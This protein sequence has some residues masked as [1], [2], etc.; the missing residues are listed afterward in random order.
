MTQLPILAE[1]EDLKRF[2]VIDPETGA[3]TM[4]EL[5]G[6]VTEKG[7]ALVMGLE[8]IEDENT[9]AQI[10]RANRAVASSKVAIDNAGK[11]IKD[12]WQKKVTFIDGER[13]RMRLA[14]EELQEQI[15]APVTEWERKEE[16]RKQR[17]TEALTDLAH[18]PHL[19]GKNSTELGEMQD[20]KE[21]QHHDFDWM[22]FADQAAEVRQK[23]LSH[24]ITART[25][26]LERE[27]EAKRQEEERKRLEEEAAEAQ[28]KAA[29]E[30]EKRRA[31]EEELAALRREKEQ[32]EAEERAK[33]EAPAPTFESKRSEPEPEVAPAVGVPLGVKTADTTPPPPTP[34][35]Q[36]KRALSPLFL[37]QMIDALINNQVP[38][39][40]YQEGANL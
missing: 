22:E 8:N 15:I 18:V 2:Y 14:L 11:D 13:R 32:R 19:M 33:Q 5:I 37:D 35:D 16:A 30:A 31:Q 38:H 12:D 25:E 17:I 10:K 34:R 26:A 29:K 28:R 20:A 27:A 9:R 36:V 7:K 24:I 23:A 39:M 40:V 1:D 21:N 4:D 6:V 3:T